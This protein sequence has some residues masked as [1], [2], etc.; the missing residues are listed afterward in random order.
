MAK[1]ITHNTKKKNLAK[2]TT[3]YGAKRGSTFEAD[4]SSRSDALEQK[5]LLCEWKDG[6]TWRQ[7]EK[8]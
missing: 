8:Q 4:S 6:K 5:A 3:L 1:L 2:S 7:T